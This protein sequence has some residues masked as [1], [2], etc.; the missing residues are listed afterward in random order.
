MRCVKYFLVVTGLQIALFAVLDQFR[1]EDFQR[2][3]YETLTDF[4]A[5][6]G[7]RMLHSGPG[8]HAM[9]AGAI[10]GLLLGSVLHLIVPPAIVCYL[11]RRYKVE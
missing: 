10:I 6:L 1:N 7:E 4:W 3:T 2:G 5:G 11:T 9:P 8:G